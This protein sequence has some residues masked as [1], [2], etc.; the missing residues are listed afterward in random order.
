MRRIA[1]FG[2]RRRSHS[3]SQALPLSSFQRLLRSDSLLNIQVPV[4]AG[5]QFG[6]PVISR[7]YRGR[8]VLSGKVLF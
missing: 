6:E 4:A 8:E 5:A 2:L 7:L 1:R 3:A